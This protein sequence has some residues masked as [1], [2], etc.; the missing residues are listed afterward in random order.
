MTGRHFYS[1]YV[2][3]SEEARRSKQKAKLQNSGYI[4]LR[5]TRLCIMWL[6]LSC[7]YLLR[8]L[9]CVRLAKTAQDVSE[10]RGLR[11]H[12]VVHSALLL[13]YPTFSSFSL[14]F[15]DNWTKTVRPSSQQ[16]LYT[17]RIKRYGPS[18]RY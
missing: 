13:L 9:V 14:S 10:R 16:N 5:G 6:V 4:L 11:G 18:N 7:R 1:R 15:S 17:L 8:A 3:D 12:V 2:R